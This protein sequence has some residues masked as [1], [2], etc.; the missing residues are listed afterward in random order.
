MAKRNKILIAVVVC[1]ILLVSAVCIFG[2]AVGG[3]PEIGFVLYCVMCSLIFSLF[4]LI[5]VGGSEYK[6]E[7]S[8]RYLL[9][10]LTVISTVCMYS[11]YNAINYLG[12]DNDFKEY[13]TTVEYFT[14]S[15]RIFGSSVGFYNPQGELV[16]TADYNAVWFDDESVPVEGAV[17]TVRE[18]NGAFNFPKYEI[19]SVNGRQEK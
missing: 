10:I 15:D 5:F 16:E 9:V 4:S 1:V 14:S 11:L 8:F 7:S 2:F 13:E 17:L 12:A 6:R 19:A 18:Y 3:R